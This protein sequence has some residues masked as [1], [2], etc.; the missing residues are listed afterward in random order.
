MTLQLNWRHQ[1]EFAGYYAALHKGFYK[2][3]GLDVTLKE[4]AP[5]LSPIDEVTQGR[6]DFG[7]SSS[8][9]VRSYLE[10]KSVLM[11]APIFQ[12][13]PEVLLSL[14]QKLH[15][16]VDV[17]KAGTIGLQPGDESLDLKAM[18]VNE[19]IALN[20]LKI[21]TETRGLQDL[22]S[23]KIVAM[24]AFLSN[25]PFW[26]QQHGIPYSTIKPAHYGMDFYNGILFTRRAVEKAHPDAV[27]AFRTATLKGWEYAL[28]NQDEIIGLILAQYNSQEKSREQLVFEAKTLADLIDSNVIRLGHSNTWRWHH[29]AETYVK[30][31]VINSDFNLDGFFYDPNPPPPD[32]SWL[33]RLFAAA[34]LAISLIAAFA[35]YISRVNRK[36]QQAYDTS[37]RALASQRQFIAMVS[38]EFRS[39]LSVIDISAQLLTRKFGDTIET[40]PVIERIHRGVARLTAFV[41]NCL[42]QE[43]FA[44]ET[45]VLH[46]ARVNLNEL[47]AWADSEQ[48]SVGHIIVSEIDPALSEM[49]GDPQLLRILLSNLLSN[50]VKYSPADSR[51]TLRFK[52]HGKN[53]RIEVI[54]Q[55][56]GIS[57]DELPVIFNKYVRGRAASSIA[58]A[59]LGLSLVKR[60]VELHG[61]T[62]HV[63]STPGEGSQFIVEI[64]LSQKTQ[65][66][67][68]CNKVPRD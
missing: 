15:T 50:A 7:I 2:E 67:T 27:S 5:N 53:C 29:I 57:A 13:S 43:R 61:G 58:G 11:L 17:L 49:D 23:G 4:G 64:P 65:I 37:E 34:L 3:A 30:F 62:I 66:K 52:L 25:E 36:L 51:I 1:F 55:G 54:D 47:A 22:L 46:L 60:I 48:T 9:L 41:D 32:M 21:N 8:G 19:G 16:P 33:Y 38:H 40:A 42:T 12:H 28:T 39:P 6:A 14:N 18:F 59:G 20:K 26:L 35:F 44:N 31:G 45:F 68:Q 56:A 10:G 24:N 63:Q